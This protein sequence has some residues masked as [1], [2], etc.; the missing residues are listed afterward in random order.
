MPAPDRSDLLPE[1]D[2]IWLRPPRKSRGPRPPLD[3]EQIVRAAVELA[4]GGALEAASTRNISA[5]LGVASASLYWHVPSKGDLHELM[6]DAIIS[7]IDLPP[8]GISWRDS[9]RAIARSVRAMFQRHPW[10]IL[11]GVQ[12]GLG[13]NNQRYAHAALTALADMSPDPNLQVEALALL[14]NYLFGF[15]HREAAWQQARNNSG[16][17][18]MQWTARLRRYLDQAASQDPASAQVLS[19]RLHLASDQS[20]E[21]GLDCL[22]DG[23]AT[24]LAQAADRRAQPPR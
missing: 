1:L 19:A 18:D 12:P 9:L 14:N 3:R 17:D 2:I 23:I 5:R 10:A 4:D 8:A 13:P 21:F 20:F 22:L 24:R 6:F 7:E 16:L 15:A 11:L